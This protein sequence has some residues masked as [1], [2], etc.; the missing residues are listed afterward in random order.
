MYEQFFAEFQ[1]YSSS[2]FRLYSARELL[3]I[4]CWDGVQQRWDSL[5]WKRLESIP[6]P[7]FWNSLMGLMTAK[8][9]A[10][11]GTASR[12]VDGRIVVLRVQEKSWAWTINIWDKNSSQTHK[13]PGECAS[14]LQPVYLY[15]LE[16]HG[17]TYGS[18]AW[19]MDVNWNRYRSTTWSSTQT[20]FGARIW[21]FLP[22]EI[23]RMWP[24]LL[25]SRW[26][27]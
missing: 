23:C 10:G 12:S 26:L 15:R 4:L 6:P 22:M 20:T 13:L 3:S 17:V 27:K 24:R 11:N 14:T 2:P 5:T 19:K 8:W 18:G 16:S 1:C 25:R 9:L 7:V 21:P